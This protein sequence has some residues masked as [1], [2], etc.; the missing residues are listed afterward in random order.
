MLDVSLH[1]IDPMGLEAVD[2]FEAAFNRARDEGKR[3]KAVLLCSPNNPLGRSITRDSL[4]SN[5]SQAGVIP[6]MY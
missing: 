2:R 1:G 5:S 3:I 4:R 6:K